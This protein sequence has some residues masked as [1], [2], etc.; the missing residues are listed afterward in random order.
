MDRKRSY[1]EISR[2]ILKIAK[3]GTRATALVYGSNLNFNIIKKYLQE[4]EASGL[5]E[6]REVPR[7]RSTTRL[8]TTTER[9]IAFMESLGET[10]DVYHGLTPV[11]TMGPV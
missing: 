10:L 6:I 8:F 11:G 2:D 7:G 5:I 9:G 4:M 3:T 1:L